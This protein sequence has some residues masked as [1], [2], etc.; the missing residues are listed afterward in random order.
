LLALLVAPT[1]AAVA[2]EDYPPSVSPASVTKS[3]QSAG[4][5]PGNTKSLAFTGSSDTIP[6]VWIAAGLV[7]FGG[8]LVFVARQRRS[9]S[10]PT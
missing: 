9:A 3:G 5:D 7:V 4:Y 1:V 8:A 6:V 2:Q 10:T